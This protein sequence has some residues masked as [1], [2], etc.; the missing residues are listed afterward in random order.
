[1]GMR[2]TGRAQEFSSLAQKP[3]SLAQRPSSSAQKLSSSAQW[4]SGS[5]S[6]V[7]FSNNW[8]SPFSDLDNHFKRKH[9]LRKVKYNK[10]LGCRRAFLE[11]YEYNKQSLKLIELAVADL[12]KNFTPDEQMQ[13][14]KSI[15]EAIASKVKPINLPVFMTPEEREIIDKALRDGQ[16]AQEFQEF[17]KKLVGEKKMKTASRPSEDFNWDDYE[18][19]SDVEGTVKNEESE[20]SDMDYDDNEDV[21]PMAPESVITRDDDGC[22]VITDITDYSFLDDKE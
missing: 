17:Q 9:R 20:E 5:D 12:S 14:E 3:S 10:K 16:I 19:K 18:L 7:P 6:D 1:M 4:S 8:K 13:L 11:R 15:K 2:L 21:K 22:S